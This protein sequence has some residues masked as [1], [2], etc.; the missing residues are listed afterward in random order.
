MMFCPTF[1][2]FSSVPELSIY[3]HILQEKQ[4]IHDQNN[5]EGNKVLRIKQH[6][7]ELDRKPEENK[8]HAHKILN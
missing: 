4:T 3:K 1:I 8:F 2:V 5:L 7:M 6:C